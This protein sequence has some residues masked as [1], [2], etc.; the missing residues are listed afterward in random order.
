M[1]ITLEVHVGELSERKRATSGFA[2]RFRNHP[3][4]SAGI[5]Y[6]VAIIAVLA[7]VARL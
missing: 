7:F 1:A 6:A 2:E 5:L 3:T 4:L